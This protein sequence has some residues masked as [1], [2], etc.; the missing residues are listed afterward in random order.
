MMNFGVLGIRGTYD[1]H[2][3]A[4]WRQSTIKMGTKGHSLIEVAGYIGCVPILTWVPKSDFISIHN[5]SNNVHHIPL[6]LI[7]GF[8]IFNM[9]KR[10]GLSVPEAIIKS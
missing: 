3:V 4:M 2:G 7:T 10:L 1:V 8:A 5:M 6:L 9:S